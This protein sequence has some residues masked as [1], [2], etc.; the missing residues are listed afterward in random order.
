M[1]KSKAEKIRKFDPNNLASEDSNI[2]GLPFNAEEADTV[3]IPVPWDVTVSYGA[4]TAKG[5]K[6]I[7]EAS[8]QVDL[9]HLHIPDAWKK[10]IYM[11]PVP[12]NI[13]ETSKK[14]RKKAEKIIDALASGSQNEDTRNLQTE[15]NHQSTQLNE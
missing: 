12:K 8:K 5:P 13:Y 1:L 3:L 6:V 14:Y 11:L 15:I 7:M 2:F 4:G 9:F 10:G